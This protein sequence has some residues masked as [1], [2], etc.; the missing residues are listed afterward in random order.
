M[1]VK[2]KRAGWDEQFSVEQTYDLDP[3]EYASVDLEGE[4]EVVES[5]ELGIKVHL[6]GGQEA[7]PE[8][9]VEQ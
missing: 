3:I 1:N 7:D 5:E 2:A 8:T 4:L 6:V 9:I